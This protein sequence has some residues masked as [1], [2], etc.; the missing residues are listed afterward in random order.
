MVW[1]VAYGSESAFSDQIWASNSAIMM[2][3]YSMGW[4]EMTYEIV[5]TIV[6]DTS[7][8]VSGIGI[9]GLD[10][11]GMVNSNTMMMRHLKCK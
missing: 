3:N 8:S 10:I 5:I 2:P 6:N 1:Q 9:T 11:K 7:Q 4:D